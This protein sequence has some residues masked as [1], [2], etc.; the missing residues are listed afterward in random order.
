M[1]DRIPDPIPGSDV[2]C[3]A[4]ADNTSTTIS[5]VNYHEGSL[6]VYNKT[7]TQPAVDKRS[8]CESA[9]HEPS[10]RTLKTYPYRRLHSLFSLRLDCAMA[11]DRSTQASCESS[12]FRR[13]TACVFDA[14]RVVDMSLCRHGAIVAIQSQQSADRTCLPIHISVCKEHCHRS[15]PRVSK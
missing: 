12:T 4:M 3:N 15:V 7:R 1:Y 10:L 9:M 2:Q 8:C 13:S 11:N 6:S 5:P 14:V